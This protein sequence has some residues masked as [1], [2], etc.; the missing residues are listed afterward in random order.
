MEVA[1][2]WYILKVDEDLL[3]DQVHENIGNAKKPLYIAFENGSFPL[4]QKWQKIGWS[5]EFILPGSPATAVM[6]TSVVRKKEESK[7]LILVIRTGLQ[8]TFLY[9]VFMLAL[10]MYIYAH[11]NILFFN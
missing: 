7:T 6:H 11:E 4:C 10:H 2:F 3:I 5:R 1:G 8:L 9:M